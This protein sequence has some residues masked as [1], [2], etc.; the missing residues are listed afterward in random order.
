MIARAASAEATRERIL[1]TAGELLRA[2]FRSEIRLQEVAEKAEV[3]VQTVINVFKTKDELLTQAVCEVNGAARELR[4]AAAPDDLKGAIHGLYAYYEAIGGWVIRNRM[5]EADQ[6]HIEAGR[7][8]HREWGE[9]Y[10]GPRLAALPAAERRRRMDALLTICSV[11]NWWL[12]RH[13]MHRSLGEA[14]AVVLL[15]VEAL[16]PSL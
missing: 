2:R 9:I 13:D 14:E 10:F 1:K 5:E 6:G 12:L 11:Y 8:R 7:K 4:R 15:T 3:T 16:L